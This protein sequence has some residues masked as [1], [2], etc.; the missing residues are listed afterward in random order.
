MLRRGTV[1]HF[2]MSMGKMYV[3]YKVCSRDHK[4]S[5]RVEGAVV[6]PS[7][8]H[9]IAPMSW[10]EALR[11]PT[12][13]LPYGYYVEEPVYVKPPKADPPATGAPAPRPNAIR[14]GPLVIYIVGQP[15]PVAVNVTFVKESDWGMVDTEDLDLRIGRDAIEQCTLFAELR[16]GG[17]LSD[18]PV[19][20]LQ[21]RGIIKCGLSESPLARRPWTR[22]KYYFI[23]ELQRGP[24]M[25][26]Y[27]GQNYRMGREWRFS[28]Y[29]KYFRPTLHRE[30]LKTKELVEGL[31]IHSSYQRTPQQAVPGWN[32]MAPS[33]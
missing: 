7:L 10:L 28:Q 25:K 13:T 27:I 20:V 29:C 6:D 18:E 14:A 26:E 5:L 11:S 8:P 4:K 15:S 31:H 22:M 32:Y 16:P 21:Q 33:P 30:S 17:L 23:E 3:D 12:T 24:G 1:W 2:R 9:C 19:S